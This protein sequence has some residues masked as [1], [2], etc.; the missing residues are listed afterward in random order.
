MSNKTQQ[1]QATLTIDGKNVELEM[2]TSTMGERALNL[3][4]LKA[5]TG[6]FAYDPAT[7]NTAVC[8]SAITYVDGDKG[9]LLHRGYPIED[10]ADNCSFIEV[11]YL[12]IHGKLP[13][14]SQRQKF[15]GLLNIHSM[16]HEDMRSFFGNYPE[17]AH[18]MAVLSAMVV[19]LSSFYPE[20]REDSGQEEIDITV[21]R[22]LSK[23]RTIAAFSYK[24]SIGEPYVYPSHK[25]SYCENFLNMM[26]RSPVSQ[27]E[28]DA[29]DVAAMNKLLILHSDHEQNASTTA[30][31]M[32]GSTG[33]NL[34]ACISAAICA[35]W[36][37]LHGGANQA[38]IEMLEGIHRDGLT[39]DQVLAKAKD[40][41]SKFRLMG[42][43]HRIYKSY[44]PRA[45]LTKKLCM[46]MAAKRKI[47]DP[48]VEI[49][50]EL[51]ARALAD[52]YFQT[53]NLYPN[54]DFYTGLT[55]RMM[56]FPKEMFTVL[57]ALGRLPGWIAHW[58]EM[59]A[60]SEQK[61]MRP[62]QIYV[63]PQRTEF[64]RIEARK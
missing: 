35:L 57:F 52:D 50:L 16:L 17:G 8:R 39:I 37:P 2:L 18:P 24:K 36:G 9:I 49:A 59:R 12:L 13:T 54:V 58:Q 55:Y 6:C 26:F 47:N 28:A 23:L 5:K 29:Y 22:L 32:V 10:L 45:R 21:T 4:G 38:V 7:V 62:R 41:N 40:R 34:Y 25:Y 60:D 44:D 27:Y 48:L 33:A 43:G 31:R 19:S 64:V 1:P 42:F 63:G 30:V 3:S 61:I 51:E 14:E 20:L 11:A 15:S 53:R 56:G 46:E